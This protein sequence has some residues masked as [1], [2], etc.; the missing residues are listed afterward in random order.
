L[1]KNL[2]KKFILGSAQFG[3]K[4]GVTNKKRLNHQNIKEI[5]KTLSKENI[6]FIDTAQSYGL[7]EKIIGNSNV[8]NFKIITKV[9]LQ[10]KNFNLHK[11]ISKSLKNLKIKKLYG[12]IIHNPNILDETM[13]K[14]IC[15]QVVDLKKRNIINKFGIS[16]YYPWELYK[17]KSLKIIDIL[18]V[19]ISIFDRRFL[20]KNLLKKIKK[21]NIEIHARSIFLQG[22][23]ISNYKDIPKKFDK[24]NNVWNKWD[25]STKCNKFE[26]LSA[27]LSFVLEKNYIDKIIVGV[28][29]LQNLKD[30]TYNFKY[31]KKYSSIP[32]FTNK[33][34]SINSMLWN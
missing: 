33:I 7:S 11:L 5:L 31:K 12:L 15:K 2:Q 10:K 19:P 3:L 13:F 17:F 26:K 20:K 14:K 34:N 32:E 25:I 30:I 28:N 27:C 6:K 1:N 8:K 22:L 23:L 16:I 4:Y 9:K 21:N 18:Q 29:S 24:W